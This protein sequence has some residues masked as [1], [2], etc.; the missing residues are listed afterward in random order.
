MEDQKRS[1]GRDSNIIS[2]KYI[3]NKLIINAIKNNISKDTIKKIYKT[4]IRNIEYLENKINY[5]FKNNIHFGYKNDS[6]YSEE[7]LI[8]GIPEYKWEE[9]SKE[10]IEFYYNYKMRIEKKSIVELIENW[11]KVFNL[12]ISNKKRFPAKKRTELSLGLI[13]EEFNELKE[14]I[15]NRDIIEVQDASGDLLWVTIRFMMEHGINPYS[16]INEIYKSNM[17]KLD[18][19]SIDAK[20]T[21]QN[22]L[23]QGVNT[24]YKK[25]KSNIMNCYV[26]ITYRESDDKILKSYTW[27]PPKF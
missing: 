24:Y 2:V 19:N 5:K 16:T 25:V 7:E 1:I 4:T 20:K 8:K 15:K 9:L 6:Y 22:Y 18:Y 12:P 11:S 27:I 10:E 21:K 17:T 26:Y 23:D 13:E 3:K 14:A